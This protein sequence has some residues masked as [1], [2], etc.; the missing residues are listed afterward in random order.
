MSYVVA[1]GKKISI[2]Y[3]EAIKFPLDS[4]GEVR[5]ISDGTKV[6]SV[7]AMPGKKGLTL[8]RPLTDL[9]I[10]Q[11]NDSIIRVSQSVSATSLAIDPKADPGSV[12]DSFDALRGDSDCKITFYEKAVD[13]CGERFGRLGVVNWRMFNQ[14]VCNAIGTWCIGKI[15]YNIGYQSLDG[16]KAIS[17]KFLN[18]KAS[19]RFMQVFSSWSG[20]IPQRI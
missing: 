2:A 1:A 19:D 3:D 4:K 16:R 8:S 18:R 20:S 17:I 11:I 13:V 12:V 7:T 9:E 5:I 6:T 10:A 14:Q 15:E